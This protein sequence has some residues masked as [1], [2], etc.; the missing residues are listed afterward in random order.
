MSIQRYNDG[1]IGF[2]FGSED[3]KVYSV[4]AS[5]GGAGYDERGVRELVCV[6]HGE[7]RWVEE[8]VE[9]TDGG[10]CTGDTWVEVFKD[11]PAKA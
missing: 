1:T 7:V 11:L 4:V 9:H 8:K 3:E 5:M 6:G 10:Y 2:E